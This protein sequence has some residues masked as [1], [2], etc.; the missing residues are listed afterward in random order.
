MEQLTE[1][2][3]KL[4]S[5]PPR[6]RQKGLTLD[7]IAGILVSDRDEVAQALYQAPRFTVQG[8]GPAKRWNCADRLFRFR[9]EHSTLKEVVKLHPGKRFA[10]LGRKLLARPEGIELKYVFSDSLE[11]DESRYQADICRTVAKWADGTD[12]LL[13]VHDTSYSPIQTHEPGE[14][15]SAGV[16]HF[17]VLGKPVYVI[18]SL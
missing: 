14:E 4:L 16:L 9:A 1:R 11:G 18:P 5:S 12:G 10:Y 15:E 6:S 3:A 8:K 17:R 7:E 13:I 2:I